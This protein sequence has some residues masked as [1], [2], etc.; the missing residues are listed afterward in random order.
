M[1]WDDGQQVSCEKENEEE[2]EDGEAVVCGKQK[3]RKARVLAVFY[4]LSF[5]LF[6]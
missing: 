4:F 1:Q 2:D 5:F 3:N 6:I